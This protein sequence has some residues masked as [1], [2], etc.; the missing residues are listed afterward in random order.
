MAMNLKCPEC[1]HEFEIE[2]SQQA[3][4]NQAKALKAQ[5]IQLKA[6]YEKEKVPGGESTGEEE[7][8]FEI[9]DL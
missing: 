2:E 7:E 8:L 9:F 5:K 4:D 1:R 3:Q 6:E